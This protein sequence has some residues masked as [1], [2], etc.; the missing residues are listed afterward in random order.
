MTTT[1]A[2][3]KGRMTVT[4]GASM[5]ATSNLWLV[6]GPFWDDGE[7]DAAMG[8][9]SFMIE[10]RQEAMEQANNLAAMASGCA[11]KVYDRT[12]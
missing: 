12:T 1:A 6:T 11:I 9:P 5:D 7:T 10:G 8:A 4:V 2:R 3:K